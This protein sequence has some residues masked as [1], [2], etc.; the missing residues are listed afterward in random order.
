MYRKILRFQMPV[1]R[2]KGYCVTRPRVILYRLR[3]RRRRHRRGETKSFFL[4]LARPSTRYRSTRPPDRVS[5]ADR[6]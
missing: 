2:P 6:F 4:P 3:R 1:K 5:G